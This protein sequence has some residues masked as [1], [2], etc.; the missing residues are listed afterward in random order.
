MNLDIKDPEVLKRLSATA[1]SRKG[2]WNKF[3]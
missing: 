1:E 2:N 3:R